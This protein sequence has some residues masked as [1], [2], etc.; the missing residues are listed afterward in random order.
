MLN[1]NVPHVVPA[2]NYTPQNAYLK[3][4]HA[5]RKTTYGETIGNARHKHAVT[6]VPLSSASLASDLG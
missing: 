1:I 5:E 6:V 3:I 4:S 2:E